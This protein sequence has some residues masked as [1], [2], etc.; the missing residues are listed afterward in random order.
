MLFHRA[1]PSSSNS[2]FQ[3]WLI[4]HHVLQFYADSYLF[5]AFFI[6]NS[7]FIIVPDRIIS[8]HQ[9]HQIQICL[10]SGTATTVKPRH[11]DGPG[12]SCSLD[13][14][15]SSAFAVP[16]HGRWC[17]TARPL[18]TGCRI[19]GPGAESAHQAIFPNTPVNMP[20]HRQRRPAR[21]SLAHSDG[22]W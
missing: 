7:P 15:P 9:P 14:R 16:P 3:V 19:P 13:L 8:Y 18:A 4:R 22:P 10:T 17:P 12:C 6:A 5:T 1:K 11:D 20:H 2:A 21:S